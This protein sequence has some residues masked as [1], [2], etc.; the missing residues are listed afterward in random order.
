MRVSK[1]LNLSAFA[2]VF[3]L[4]AVASQVSA[5]DAG[6]RLPEI[7]LTD[8][9]GKKVDLASLKGKVVIVDFWASWCAPCAEELPQ[10]EKLHKKYKDRG[11]VVVGVSVDE[12][13][14]NLTGFLK[15]VKLSFPIVHDKA[16]AVADRFHPPRMPSSYIADRNG[17]VRHVH[18]GYRS[19]DAQQFETE[20]AALL[21]AQ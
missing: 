4:F 12:E 6:T 8:L 10:L 17:V 1:L 3:V 21:G 7:G 15:K 11:L 9:S 18:G 2:A 13:A 5:L 20:V 16:H 14:E 19:G